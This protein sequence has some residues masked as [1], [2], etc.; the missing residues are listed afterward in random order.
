MLFQTKQ[1]L[2]DTPYVEDSTTTANHNVC[3]QEWLLNITKSIKPA[4]ANTTRQDVILKIE[5][6]LSA[7]TTATKNTSDVGADVNIKRGLTMKRKKRSMLLKQ[8][9]VEEIIKNH[10]KTTRDSSDISLLKCRQKLMEYKRKLTNIKASLHNANSSS[11]DPL[12][13]QLIKTSAYLKTKIS[14]IGGIIELKR[15]KYLY[16]RE[17]VSRMVSGK[18]ETTK[19][20]IIEFLINEFDSLFEDLCSFQKHNNDIAS[21]LATLLNTINLLEECT[22]ASIISVLEEESRSSSKKAA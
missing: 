7:E 16:K 19:E 15:S 17:V 11:C 10:R 2:K 12:K 22:E 20:E 21:G 18:T 8:E 14:T 3:I 1:Q 6:S 4:I 13:E 5:Q 9:E